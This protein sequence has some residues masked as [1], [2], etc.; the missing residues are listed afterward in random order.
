LKERFTGRLMG[1]P[2]KSFRTR[3]DPPFL[4]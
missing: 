1:D 3:F 2:D 4:T